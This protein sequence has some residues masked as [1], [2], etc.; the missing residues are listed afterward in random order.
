MLIL[1]GQMLA[2]LGNVVGGGSIRLQIDKVQAILSCAPPMT[3]KSVRSFLGLV[4]WYRRFVPNFASRAAVLTDF[5]PQRSPVKVKRTSECEQA[6][7]DLKA[8]LC[9][10]PILQSPNFDL[11]FVVQ[12]DASDDEP[13]R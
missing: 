7:Q 2:Y 12:T 5:L 1:L 4:G 3:K 8:C 6:F 9:K 11:P 13:L 10:D